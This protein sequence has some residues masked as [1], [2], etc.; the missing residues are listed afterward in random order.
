MD[1]DIRGA[2]NNMAQPS[3]ETKT[4][5]ILV[6]EDFNLNQ[7]VVRLMLAD[8]DY[9][10]IF[11]EN[12]LEAVQLYKKDPARFP[13]ILMD[14]SMPVMDGHEAT[15]LIKAHEV[16]QKL[17]A[18]PIIALTG[19]ALKNDREECLKAGM[20]DH[21]SKPVNQSS[22]LEKIVFWLDAAKQQKA[23]A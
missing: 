17:P 21:L 13:L 16:S 1:L 9:Q 23:V 11:V 10:P 4:T 19:H 15:R 20:S 8:T 6:A 7:D 5:E 22:L 12:G 14:V 3:P 18:T 2:K